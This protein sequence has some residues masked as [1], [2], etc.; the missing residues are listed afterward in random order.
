MIYQVNKTI[1][2]SVELREAFNA[3]KDVIQSLNQLRMSDVVGKRVVI[4]IK[5]E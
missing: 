3:N 5:I 2:T 1:K 4:N